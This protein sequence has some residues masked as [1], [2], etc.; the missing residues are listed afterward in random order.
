ME[1]ELEA[2]L[3]LKEDPLLHEEQFDILPT[4]SGARFI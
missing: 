2:V 1:K 4:R 3:L